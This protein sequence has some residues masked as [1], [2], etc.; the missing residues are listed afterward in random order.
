MSDNQNLFS[1]VK[2]RLPH[3]YL[4]SYHAALAE[5][6]FEGQD[7]LQVRISSE[8][9]STKPKGQSLPFELH[10]DGLY[11]TP[12]KAVAAESTPPISNN[13]AWARCKRSPISVFKW[14]ERANVTPGQVWLIVYT[15]FTVWPET[16]AF[17]VT[18]D[19]QG[20]E[21]I[22]KS[23]KD[24]MLAIAH[25]RSA[26]VSSTRDDELLILR[27][28]FWQGA[29]SPFG[30]P[31]WTP[32]ARSST[33]DPV[34]FT[35]TA[36]ERV[37]VRHPQ[38]PE[39]PEPG[40]VVYSRYISSLDEH[41]S[42]IAIDYKNDDH[43]KLF[44]KWQNDPRV[45]KGWNETGTFEEHREYLRKQHED[46]HSLPVF[47]RFDDTCFSYFEVF[48]A[49]EDHVGAY[50]ASGDFD[51]GRHSLVGESAFRGRHRVFGWW[52]SVIHYSFLDDHRTSTVIGEPI[53][54]NTTVQVY[55]YTFGLSISH[56]I[57]LPHKRSA[58]VM[59]SRERFFQICPFNNSDT[60]VAGTKL[61][62]PSKL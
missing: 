6:K 41:F 55:D 11:F 21:E 56:F 25:P 23:L 51:K 8:V 45:A 32:T 9:E 33:I 37:H 27:S 53:A 16:E 49:K 5:E 34:Y 38:R 44:H 29:G 18:L 61:S 13:T 4:T 26:T 57:D 43:V 30:R 10:N 28:T 15:I 14:S 20:G 58:L 1:P 31:A 47:G 62:L 12:P 46:P 48:W 39:K 24:S 36:N 19:G 42:L 17:R 54:T 22:K 60:F 59:T 50:Y 2:L 3:P 35:F 40:S 7:L 52:P